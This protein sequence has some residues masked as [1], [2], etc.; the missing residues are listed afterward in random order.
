VAAAPV[1]AKSGTLG[2]NAP[3]TAYVLPDWPFPITPVTPP[4][5]TSGAAFG[6]N[7]TVNLNIRLP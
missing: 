2:G 3:S 6:G 4:A 1:L 5:V 7:S